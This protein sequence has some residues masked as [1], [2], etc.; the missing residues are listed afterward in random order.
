MNSESD[1]CTKWLGLLSGPLTRRASEKLAMNAVEQPQSI[2]CLFSV[3]RTADQ[4]KASRASWVLGHL[5]DIS[6]TSL[7]LYMD[8]VVDIIIGTA[9][10]SVRRN[11][12]RIVA[13]S[14]PETSVLMALFE[15]CIGC[16]I[17]ERHAVAV[18]CNAMQLLYLT[19]K[20]E[21]DLSREVKTYI[22]SCIGFGS[23]AFK[24][25]GKAIV[26][27]LSLLEQNELAENI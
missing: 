6:P 16:M 20:K 2:E 7:A 11:F 12:L 9:H 24:A 25:R 19:C 22:E 18:R 15:H 17:S 4:V 10:E 14:E 27:Q 8:D 13:D 21:P 26:K 23:A 5:W 3:V 1:N